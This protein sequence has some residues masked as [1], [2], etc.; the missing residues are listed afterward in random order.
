MAI[1]NVEN[2]IMVSYHGITIYH[3]YK[4]D[5]IDMPPRE[6]CFTLE[7]FGSE[8]DEDAFDIRDLSGYDTQ[9]PYAANLVAMIDAGIF[10][11]TDLL[12]REGS[13]EDTTYAAE[14]TRPG[15]C[16]VCG[17]HL[18]E[19]GC[20]EVLDNQVK[21]PF[22]CQ[23]CGVSGAEWGDIVFDGYTVP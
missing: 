8:L 22:T 13:S 10:G 14:D 19:Y 7:P 16:P 15:I 23:N 20:F 2:G 3:T 21:Y 5:L 17:T 6:C 9:K 4:D 18:T 1:T 12:E 11:E